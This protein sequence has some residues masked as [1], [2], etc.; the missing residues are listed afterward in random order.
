MKFLK[1]V[2]SFVALM[3]AFSLEAAAHP[4]CKGANC[5]PHEDCP[6]APPSATVVSSGSPTMVGRRPL[7]HRPNSASPVNKGPEG[8]NDSSKQVP[9]CPAENHG[10][11]SS[12]SS[13]N[14]LL[15]TILKKLDKAEEERKVFQE[16]SKVFQEVMLTRL[17]R[18]ESRLDIIEQTSAEPHLF[19]PD[20]IETTSSALI[21]RTEGTVFCIEFDNNA[22]FFSSTHEWA[23]NTKASLHSHPNLDITLVHHSTIENTHRRPF[24]C[25]RAG[26]FPIVRPGDQLIANGY[27]QHIIRGMHRVWLVAVQGMYQCKNDSH[28]MCLAVGGSQVKGMS[29]CPVFNGCGLVGIAYQL[30]FAHWTESAGNIAQVNVI[31]ISALLELIGSEGVDEFIVPPS[32]IS[33]YVDIPRKAHCT[34]AKYM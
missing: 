29:G 24:T 28:H 33:S 16:E 15:E 11:D 14:D 3:S 5:G 22:Y 9:L 17:D 26:K 8:P 10:N 7:A 2:V 20:L 32:M 23:N 27:D 21:N 13:T 4:S 30:E 25:L 6:V 19:P 31:P 1:V 12:S 34:T 18:V